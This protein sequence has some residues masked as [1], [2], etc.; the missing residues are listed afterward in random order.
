MILPYGFFGEGDLWQAAT[1][2][3]F[4]MAGGYVGY[5]PAIPTGHSRWPIMAGLY[6]VAGVPEAGDQL[7]AY[8]ANHD[9]SA[10][11]IGPRTNY[12]VCA[13][14]RPTHHRY[15]AAMADD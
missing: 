2:M 12:L 14:G 13:Y 3:Y 8:L 4:R 15:L 6:G 9:V 10:I 5:A 7:K 11:I 1:D